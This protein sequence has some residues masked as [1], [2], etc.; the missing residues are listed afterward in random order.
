VTP[1]A[2]AALAGI[3]IIVLVCSQRALKQIPLF[4]D[5]P[6]WVLAFCVALLSIVGLVQFFGSPEQPA[7]SGGEP[8]EPGGLLDFVLLPYVALALSI[9][10]VLLLRTLGKWSPNKSATPREVRRAKPA[11]RAETLIRQRQMT[12]KAFR[13]RS[14]EETSA[15]LRQGH[16]E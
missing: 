4:C 11:S 5:G 14:K 12:P 9:L 16:L 10:F 8:K 7:R 15:A 3:F 13:E 6:T 1:I 2:I